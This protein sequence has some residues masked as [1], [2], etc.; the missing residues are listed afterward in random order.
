MIAI[1]VLDQLNDPVGESFDD[2][3]NLR[4]CQQQE[5]RSMG[6]GATDLLGSRDK[7]NHLL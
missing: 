4:Y 2:Q 3:A 5:L 7:L 1:Q 6:N